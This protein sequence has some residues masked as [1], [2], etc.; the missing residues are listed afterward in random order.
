MTVVL[1]GKEVLADVNTLRISE[2]RS[3]CKIGPVSN[4]E[5]NADAEGEGHVKM[6]AETGAMLS[7]AR[8]HLEPPEARRRQRCF[9]LETLEECGPAGPLTSDFWTPEL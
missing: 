7:Q 8:E 3:R 4:K 2:M 1:V 9:S 5:K 6:E